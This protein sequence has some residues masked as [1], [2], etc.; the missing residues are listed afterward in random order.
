MAGYTPV[1]IS[2]PADK[3]RT[4]PKLKVLIGRLR[5]VTTFPDVDDKGILISGNITMAATATV[6]NLEVTPGSIDVSQPSDGDPD[7][8]GFKP[9][10]VVKRPGG[11]DVAFDEFVENNINEDLFAV[12]QYAGGKN[13]VAGYPGNPLQ[14]SVESSDNAEADVSTLTLEAVMRGRR[15]SH[16][17]GTIPA[18]AAVAVESDSGAGA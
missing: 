2:R 11:Q 4:K 7:S 6:I 15:I 9:K 13:K 16:Y 14:M 18:I 10:I 12:I 8:K 1:S 5:E 17:A 3:G